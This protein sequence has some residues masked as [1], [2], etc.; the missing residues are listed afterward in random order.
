M[1]RFQ[2]KSTFLLAIALATALFS[3]FMPHQGHAYDTFPT[4][5]TTNL[6]QIQGFNSSKNTA[7]WLGV[8][9]AKPPVGDLRWRAPQPPEPWE[10]VWDGTTHCE[11]CVQKTSTPMTDLGEMLEASLTGNAESTLFGSEDCLYLNIFRPNTL[12]EDLPVYVFIHGGA[13]MMGQIEGYDGSALAEKANMVVVFVQYRLGPMGYFSHPVLRHGQSQLD[14]SG[15]FGT[16]DNIQAL[17]WIQEN[18]AAFG[19]NPDNVTIGGQSG[20]ALNVMNLVIS[21]LAEGLFHRAMAESPAFFTITQDEAELLSN[22][23]V[24]LILEKDGYTMEDWNGW[25]ETEKETYLK[26]A[27]S[28][29]LVTLSTDNA[30]LLQP[31][32]SPGVIP[33]NFV[34][35]LGSGDYNKV[36]I[37]LGTNRYE[38]KGMMCGPLSAFASMKN[39]TWKELPQVL[40]GD[41]SLDDILPTQFDKHLYDITADFGSKAW[42]IQAVDQRARVMKMHQNDIY[43]FRFDWCGPAPFDFIIGGM[44]G[45]DLLFFLGYDLSVLETIFPE[46]FPDVLHGQEELVDIMT[47]YLGNFARSGNPNGQGLPQWQQWSNASNGPK[48]VQLDA[49]AEQAIVTMSNEELF[50]RDV[51]TE[52]RDEITTWSYKNKLAYGLVPYMLPMMSMQLQPEEIVMDLGL[53]G[54]YEWETG[55]LLRKMLFSMMTGGNL[56]GIMP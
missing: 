55:K 3:S 15:T 27:D 34:S 36:P 5:V 48:V 10:G 35:T 1:K 33:G 21:P 23:L 14:D 52:M 46:M 24:E 4:L 16:L 56:T 25:T 39:L 30:L 47:T 17:K 13:N 20:G 42:R 51:R 43:A 18:I 53:W 31:I 38:F 2:N 8:P 6:G 41:K 26:S 37:M 45:M 32:Q 12:E 29:D 44:H 11:P 28:A 22:R 49:D 40:Q 54:R 19:G 9:F 50:I 7:A